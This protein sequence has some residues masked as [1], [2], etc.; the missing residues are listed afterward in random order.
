MDSS[1]R[2]IVT[3]CK[4]TDCFVGFFCCCLLL[5]TKK[6]SRIILWSSTNKEAEVKETH[7]LLM[8]ISTKCIL[9]LWFFFSFK[10]II[11]FTN[12][13]GKIL[14]TT[15][16]CEW[17]RNGGKKDHTLIINDRLELLIYSGMCVVYVIFCSTEEKKNDRSGSRKLYFH[18][19]K[20]FCFFI[21]H[22]IVLCGNFND[23]FRDHFT[24]LPS[25]FML[26]QYFPLRRY[27]KL[28][29]IFIH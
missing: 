19:T 7:T 9:K 5:K 2:I 15:C 13:S 17:Q 26:P 25:H 23:L 14:I 10:R 1:H 6:R 22:S 11:L 27:I 20:W 21:A 18:G 29:A 4:Y 28:S 3:S 24:K 8:M 16:D 12:Y